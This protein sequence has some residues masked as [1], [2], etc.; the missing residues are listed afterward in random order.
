MALVKEE[1]TTAH[2][3]LAL[4]ETSK[5]HGTCT[6]ASYLALCKGELLVLRQEVHNSHQFL[7][8]C[9]GCALT[10]FLCFNTIQDVGLHSSMPESIKLTCILCTVPCDNRSSLSK[11]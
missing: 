1:E 10:S 3:A 6:T 9:G 2:E 11:H 8:V 7:E 4:L 5:A